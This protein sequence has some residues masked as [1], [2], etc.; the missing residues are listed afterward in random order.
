MTRYDAHYTRLHNRLPG[1]D[2]NRSLKLRAP[3]TGVETVSNS[4][5][6]SGGSNV[7]TEESKMSLGKFIEWNISW[8]TGRKYTNDGQII[9]ARRNSDGTIVFADL[10]R[11]ID[12]EIQGSAMT[13]ATAT[14]TEFKAFVLK[15]YDAGD[16]VTNQNS[17][18]YY[19]Q[20]KPHP[21]NRSVNETSG[22]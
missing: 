13:T 9:H 16:Y 11:G 10:S 12:G 19:N 17:Y 5:F 15:H 1:S 7:L 3:E 14:E 4:R 8:N 6:K 20:C 22:K 21:R 18:A 2:G